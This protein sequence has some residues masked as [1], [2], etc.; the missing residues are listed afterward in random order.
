[1]LMATYEGNENDNWGI[2]AKRITR[3]NHKTLVACA[4]LMATVRDL[5]RPAHLWPAQ[6][7]P[8]GNQLEEKA[9]QDTQGHWCLYNRTSEQP[10]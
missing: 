6:G 5:R 2:Q 10:N 7:L 3:E 4:M 8:L 9:K 1:M